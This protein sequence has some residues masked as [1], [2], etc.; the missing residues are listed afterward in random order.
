MTPAATAPHP[1]P[2]A[3]TCPGGCADIKTVDDRFA[4]GDVRMGRI[5]ATQ[6]AM[7][8]E[9]TAMRAEVG[10]VLEILRMGKSFF[11]LAGYVGAL[12]RW[13]APIGAACWS[14]YQLVKNGGKS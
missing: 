6:Q 4:D 14:I 2:P 9:Q 8:T 7:S 1:C 12:V 5:E 13:A 10:E 3:N 11:K